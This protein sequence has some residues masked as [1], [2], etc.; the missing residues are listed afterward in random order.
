MLRYMLD[1]CVCIDILRGKQPALRPRIKQESRS[2]CIS[3]ITYY[4][5][6]EG[7]GEIKE[8]K[9]RDREFRAVE[10][11]T[12]LLTVLPFNTRAAEEA[13]QITAKLAAEDN[14]I[15]QCDL[16]IAG[17]VRSLGLNIVTGNLDEFR[18]VHDLRSEA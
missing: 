2:L 9:R 17:H 3:M 11:L 13:A 15:G 16:L 10:P 6:R 5:L 14:I 4:G 1:I 12:R 8:A 7:V 18:R